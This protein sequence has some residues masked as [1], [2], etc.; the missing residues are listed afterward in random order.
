MCVKTC[1][2]CVVDVNV[3]YRTLDLSVGPT[4]L[5]MSLTVR[6]YDNNFSI[7]IALCS[8]ETETH[9]VMCIL[10]PNANRLRCQ[11]KKEALER[12]R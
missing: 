1:C 5:R 9:M 2:D 7:V 3:F 4:S 10:L 8:F 12:Q 11:I 6:S